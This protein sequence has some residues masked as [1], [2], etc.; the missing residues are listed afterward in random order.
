MSE[1]IATLCVVI[2]VRSSFVI[3]VAALN[4]DFLSQGSDWSYPDF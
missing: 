3:N 4:L 2:A 1:K